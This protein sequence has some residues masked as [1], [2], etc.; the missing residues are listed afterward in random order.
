MNIN[1]RTQF[2]Y[3]R[4]IALSFNKKQEKSSVASNNDSN[5]KAAEKSNSLSLLNQ[6]TMN[7]IK[8]LAAAKENRMKKSNLKQTI[9]SES[10]VKG[11]TDTKA[12]QHIIKEKMAVPQDDINIIES[13]EFLNPHVDNVSVVKEGDVLTPQFDLFEEEQRPATVSE[14]VVELTDDDDNSLEELNNEEN[15]LEDYDINDDDIDFVPSNDDYKEPVVNKTTLKNGI[16]KT[17]TIYSDNLAGTTIYSEFDKPIN[18]VKSMQVYKFAN[19]DLSSVETRDENNELVKRISL[20]YRY[21]LCDKPLKM[22]IFDKKKGTTVV[23]YNYNSN[24]SKLKSIIVSK[25][26][27][28]ST[29]TKAKK[30]NNK[31][32]KFSNAFAAVF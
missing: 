19:G 29:T 22:R 30:Q 25:P 11:K 1:L 10:Q 26:D 27:G 3:E 17:D 32:P 12:P 21:T 2:P 28:T 14:A 9:P 20:S 5:D 4:K 23:Y 6:I 24:Y 8:G 7:T 18:G 16:T 31:M 13:E 15:V